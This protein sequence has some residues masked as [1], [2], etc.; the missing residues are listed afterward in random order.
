MV[1]RDEYLQRQER[2]RRRMAGRG[3]AALLV[4]GGPFYARCGDV[5]YLCG[6]LPPFPSAEGAGGVRGTG[7]AALVVDAS[8][9]VLVVDT[10]CHREELVVASE[11]RVARDLWAEAASL[12]AGV[13]GPV[14]CVGSDIVPWEGARSLEQEGVRLVPADGVVRELRKVKSPAEVELLRAA[15]ACAREAVLACASACVPGAREQEVAASGAAA[16]LRA[17]ADFVRYVRVHSG[18][19][20]A[21]PTRWPPATD[22][23]LQKSDLVLVDAV[24]ARAGYAFD[25]GRTILVGFDALPWQRQLFEAT[26]RALSRALSAVRP[27]VTVAEV[28][29]AA[30][31]AYEAAGLGAHASRFLGHGV[32]L[33]T[34]EAPWLVPDSPEVLQEGMVLCVEPAVYLPGAGGVC[35]EEVVVVQRD[36]CRIL[37]GD[38][39]RRLWE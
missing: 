21:W 15:C 36:G 23:V 31:Q 20:S 19:W 14:G 35:V 24:G 22:R 25:V 7:H 16:G 2:V 17:G 1:G 32:G 39:P 29:G 13:S 5:A 4:V 10:P 27:G 28:V 18:P 8:R 12:L 34:V 6:H 11:V 33:E 30:L 3:L 9:A 38:A 26:Q 37:T